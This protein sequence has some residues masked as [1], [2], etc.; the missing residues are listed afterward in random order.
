MDK[1][2]F[3]NIINQSLDRSKHILTVKALEYVRGEDPLSNFNKG[4]EM[5]NQTRE[6]VLYG[7]ML[8][9]LVS[10]SDIIDDIENDNKLPSAALLE[11]KLTDIIN[12]CL[13][14]EASIKDKHEKPNQ[15]LHVYP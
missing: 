10:L 8:K 12:Y 2:T 3:K 11:E 7:Y 4:A 13:I 15:N 6:K 9:H 5:S 14:L 1:S